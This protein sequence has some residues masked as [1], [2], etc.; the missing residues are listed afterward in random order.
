[1]ERVMQGFKTVR[2]RLKLLSTIVFF[3][4][5]GSAAF[6]YFTLG[7]L[8]TRYHKTNTISEIQ[9]LLTAL[10][11]EGLQ[12]G[13]AL[14]NVHID[15][16]DN[17]AFENLKKA[18]AGVDRLI[19]ELGKDEITQ[20]SPG[21][22]NLNI[23]PLYET[24]AADVKR[25]IAKKES[26]EIISVEDIKK[27]TAEAWRPFKEAIAKWRGK[28]EE[29][30]TQ[31]KGEFDTELVATKMT[32]LL[33][34]SFSTVVVLLLMIAISSKITKSLDIFQKGIMRFFAFL[35]RE[36][37]KVE[38]IELRSGDEFEVMAKSVNA[39]I[40]QA[41]N[42]IKKNKDF[43]EDVNRFAK[44][45]SNGKFTSTIE[46]LSDDP[47]L[48]ALKATL[49]RVQVDLENNIARDLNTLLKILEQF[50]E[51][52]F[53]PRFQSCHAKVATAVNNLG[54]EICKMLSGSMDMGNKLN[55]SAEKLKELVGALNDSSNTQAASIEE[56][57]AALEQ[58]TCSSVEASHKTNTIVAQGE[59]IKSVIGLISDIADQ[60]NLLA[61]NAAIEAARA[62][63]HG[64]GFAV[65]ADEVRKLAEKTQKSLTDINSSVSVLVQSIND[66]D[67]M[68]K[69]QT[70]AIE[71][72]NGAIQAID[73][74]TQENAMKANDANQISSEIYT[75]SSEVVKEASSKKFTKF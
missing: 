55:D 50:K 19:A 9:V 26:G 74:A 38:P 75:I 6:V 16:T 43:I 58:L 48:K 14:R 18:L 54:D 60:T 46:K 47:D 64:R 39:A 25:L 21:M 73:H 42:D 53:T 32:V 31:L 2:G 36:S 66:I 45:L 40:E 56:T 52:D 8:D 10:N 11:G 17:K 7:S 65:V 70:T 51:Q 12:C 3:I 5:A 49:D 57:S 24:F 28:N 68:L 33:G 44:D 15:P 20:C 4:I 62:G 30:V 37:D 59:D 41:F 1:M 61:L 34:A 23:Y 29:K 27:N 67:D 13:Q 35:N 71:E 22:K 63:E 69:Q 72:I